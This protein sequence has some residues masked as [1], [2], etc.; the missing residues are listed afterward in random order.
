[1]SSTPPKYMEDFEALISKI[2]VLPETCNCWWRK[3]TKGLS[4]LKLLLPLFKLKVDYSIFITNHHKKL[5][6]PTNNFKCLLI[7]F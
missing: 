4:P 5:N 7:C 1:M 6:N 3:L 2:N